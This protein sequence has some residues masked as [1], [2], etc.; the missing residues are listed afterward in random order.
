M[1]VLLRHNCIPDGCSN[2]S[3]VY[4]TISLEPN[5][6]CEN[7]DVRLING[8]A[9]SEGRVEVCYNSHWGT[10]CHNDWED[11]DAAVV[12]AE[13]GYERNGNN[14]LFSLSLSASY[15]SCML[16]SSVQAPL[17]SALLTLVEVMV[18]FFCLMWTAMEQKRTLHSA[19]M[20]GLH[21]TSVSTLKMQE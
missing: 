13:L 4:L 2:T 17:L 16:S 1:D 12:C 19:R 18:L 6:T 20:A 10:I 3:E 21:N 15:S 11:D 14:E 9:P 5:A 8:R 7:G